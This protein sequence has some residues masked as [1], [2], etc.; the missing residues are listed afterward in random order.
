MLAG[1]VPGA[2]WRSAGPAPSAGLS[3]AAG[4]HRQLTILGAGDVLLHPDLWEQARR[5][6]AA[7]GR[8]GLDFGPLFQGVRDE[9]SAADL[10]ICHMETVLAAPEGPFLGFPRFSVPP[11]IA[12]TLADIGYD[13]CSTAS[14]HTLDQG[15]PGIE[16][17]LDALDA[18]KISHAGSYRTK[19]EHDTVNML[20]VNGVK[21]AHL[22]YT[23]GFNGLKRP[24][25]REWVANQIN[26]VAILAEAHRAKQQGAAIVVLSLHWGTEYEHSPNPDQ[27]AL[28]RQLL[29]SPDIDLILGCHP[30]VVQQFEKVGD[31]WVV[32]SMGNQVAHHEKPIEDNREGVLPRFTFTETAPGVWKVTRAEAIPVWMVLSPDNRLIN[33]AEAIADQATPPAV[34]AT[35]RAELIRVAGFLNSRNGKRDG[36][37]IPGLS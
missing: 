12:P 33:L 3:P 29:A 18:A 34:R 11:Q 28:A 2:T 37:V 6:A 7:N 31:E 9:I 8:T 16:R 35:Y 30:H 21:V 14:N 20:T 15:E 1:C 23:F 25:G 26:P 5:D 22:S 36:L 13:T 10:A 32:Y 19:A 24:D 4:G 17:T 27:T